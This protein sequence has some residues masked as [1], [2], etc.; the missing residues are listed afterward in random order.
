MSNCLKTPGP[1]SSALSVFRSALRHTLLIALLPWHFALAEQLPEHARSTLEQILQREEFQP[2]GAKP[3]YWEKIFKP[4]TEW[5]AKVSDQLLEAFQDLLPDKDSNVA[6]FAQ[7]LASLLEPLAVFFGK[8]VEQFGWLVWVLM[9]L[10]GAYL[11]FK[12]VKLVSQFYSGPKTPQ[13]AALP[14]GKQSSRREIDPYSL[15]STE[16][17]LF[18]LREMLRRDLISTYSLSNSLTDRELKSRLNR[19]APHTQVF[20]T[21][22]RL[23][24]KLEYAG[25]GFSAEAFE[26]V[27]AEYRQLP[28]LS[29]QERRA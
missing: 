22:S 15:G 12:L 13:A 16:E 5:F 17:A 9:A 25:L 1:P 2:R 7:W 29:K 6:V 11:L 4:I 21:V 10:L 24:E 19:N 28:P 18:A 14:G 23:F 20:D 27:L 3:S 26:Q 8:L